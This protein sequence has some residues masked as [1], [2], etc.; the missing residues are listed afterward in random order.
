MGHRGEACLAFQLLTLI[1]DL[2]IGCSIGGLTFRMPVR[3]GVRAKYSDPW[4]RSSSGAN[5]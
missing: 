3:L 5:L 4:S 1:S 2:E